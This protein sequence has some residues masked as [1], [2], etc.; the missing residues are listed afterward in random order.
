MDQLKLSDAGQAAELIQWAAA[1]KK[2][3]EICAG[4]SKRALGRPVR[5]DLRV[6]VAGLSGVIEYEPEELVLTARA[7][8]PMAEIETLLAQKDQMLAFEPPDW[9]GLLGSD[10]EPTHWRRAGLQSR[11]APPGASRRRARLFSRLFGHQRPGRG[12]Q[13]RRQ[14]GQERHR[15]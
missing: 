1:E 6:D 4:G 3:L 8:T 15:L 13:G 7:A 10:G 12:V 5:A 11:R 14:G 9:R 2:S